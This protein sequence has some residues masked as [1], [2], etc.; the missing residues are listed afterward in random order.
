M[1]YESTLTA[2]ADPTRRKIFEALSSGPCSVTQLA[3]TQ[4]VSR[5]AVSQHLKVLEQAKLVQVTPQ[6]SHRLYA[7]RQEGLQALQSY[8]SQFWDDALGAYGAEV[9]RRTLKN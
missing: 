7:I 1:T 8:L 5:P 2:L 4:T 9:R 3:K 6:G